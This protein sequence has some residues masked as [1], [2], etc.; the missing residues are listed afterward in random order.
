MPE[1]GMMNELHSFFAHTY[2]PG[3]LE[4]VCEVGGRVM[5]PRYFPLKFRI[6]HQVY[7]IVETASFSKDSITA[8][9]RATNVTIWTLMGEI[10]HK[11][12][13]RKALF[14]QSVT[15]VAQ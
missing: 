1:H 3:I 13:K 9:S 6:M 11:I 7:E 5:D 14:L 12:S 4:E 10:R 8:W 15:R 2:M